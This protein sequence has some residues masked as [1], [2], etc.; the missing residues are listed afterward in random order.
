MASQCVNY[1]GE[2][3]VKQM[4]LTLKPGQL[5]EVKGKSWQVVGD[6]VAKMAQ[7]ELREMWMQ[8]YTVEA[9][10]GVRAAVKG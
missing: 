5:I 7:G 8:V 3:V 1:D 4:D 10:D 9:A 2:I 6:P